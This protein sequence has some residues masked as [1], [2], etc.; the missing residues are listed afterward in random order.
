[1]KNLQK[2]PKKRSASALDYARE[3]REIEAEYGKAAERELPVKHDT[4]RMPVEELLATAGVEDEESIARATQGSHWDSDNREMVSV[5]LAK[6][7]ESVVPPPAAAKRAPAPAPAPVV[8]AAAVAE[9]VKPRIYFAQPAS[10]E[11]HRGPSTDRMSP[12]SHEA[13][14]R[15][16]TPPRQASTTPM[17]GAPGRV[18]ARGPA[19]TPLPST[20][21]PARAAA[22]ELSRATSPMPPVAAERARS[23]PVPAKAQPV[24]APAPGRVSARLAA[25]VISVTVVLL[26]TVAAAFAWAKKARSSTVPAGLAEPKDPVPSSLPSPSPPAPEASSATAPSEGVAPPSAT[27]TAPAAAPA[28]ASAVAPKGTAPKGIAPKTASPTKAPVRPATKGESPSVGM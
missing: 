7:D 14:A 6:T 1:M 17:I 10:E 5:A 12:N 24:S 16:N 18:P 23:I 22:S 15:Q 27:P 4:D 20:P 25:V 2:D 21:A 26:C 28:Q 9:T 8:S 13:A 19:P 3:L 11:P